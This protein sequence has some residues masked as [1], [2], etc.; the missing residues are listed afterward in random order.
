MNF[1]KTLRKITTILKERLFEIFVMLIVN[2]K[3]NKDYSPNG[4][5]FF[6]NSKDIINWPP[7][8]YDNYINTLE[9]EH[10]DYSNKNSSLPS[11]IKVLE[12]YTGNYYKSI[13]DFLRNNKLE[14]NKCDTDFIKVIKSEFIRSPL[15][16]NIVVI[17]RVSNTFLNN[18]LLNKKELKVGSTIKDKAFLSTSID[19]SYRKD[20]ESVYKPIND[21]TL[22]FIKVC[23]K[24]PLIYLEP[25]S[26]RKEFE[27]LL[28]NS[29]EIIIESAYNIFNNRVIF[30]RTIL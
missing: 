19:L 9:K 3:I 4:I 7:S 10:I 5:L 28:P 23:N 16:G 2:R 21:E 8:I 13:N 27:L 12:Y 15:K 25:F 11:S 24:T 1:I 6:K 17:R 30:S 14:Y 20:N 22:I 29:T 18:Y 26:N